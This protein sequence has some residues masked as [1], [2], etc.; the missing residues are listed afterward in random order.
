[1]PYAWQPDAPDGARRL[2]IWR[3]RSLTAHGFVWF[4][5][6]T[7]LLLVLPLVALT[8]SAVMW[9]LLPFA[10]AALAGLWWAMQRHWRGGGSFEELTLTPDTLLVSRHD[11]G[12]PPRHWQ[13]NPYWVRLTL[14]RDGPVE[15]YLT[16]TDGQREIELGALLSPE[17]R[18]QLRDDLAAAL[19]D[20]NPR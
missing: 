17:E 7:A 6:A 13:A 16:L 20:L 5:G 14:R 1:M 12:R 3:H 4:I 19:G 15:D 18:R 2:L 10:L 9:G 8:G 11:P